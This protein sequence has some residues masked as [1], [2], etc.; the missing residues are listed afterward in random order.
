MVT[1]VLDNIYVH[2]WSVNLKQAGQETC[3]LDSSLEQG[4]FRG[5]RLTGFGRVQTNDL[6]VG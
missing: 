4:M 3:L 6:C 2:V 5:Q 1:K